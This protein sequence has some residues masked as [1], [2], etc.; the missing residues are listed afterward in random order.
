[1]IKRFLDMLRASQPSFEQRIQCSP[2]RPVGVHG[3][4]ITGLGLMGD[5]ILCTRCGRERYEE[6]WDLDE[7]ARAVPMVGNAEMF[8]E[9]RSARNLPY[10]I[11]GEKE[12]RGA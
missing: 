11:T 4:L 1:M 10:G 12:Y 9:V 8:A 2:D 3:R 5:S 6:R 7:Q